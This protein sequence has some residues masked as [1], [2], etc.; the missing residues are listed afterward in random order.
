MNLFM[1]E[2]DLGKLSSMHMYAWQSKLK[3]GMYYLR[4]KPAVNATKFTVESKKPEIK[5]EAIDVN[6]FRAMIEQGRNAEEN[7]DDC[8]ACGS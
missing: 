8:I 6:D 4:S 7:G 1:A 2:P 3:T 5:V